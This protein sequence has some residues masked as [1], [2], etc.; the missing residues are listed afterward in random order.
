MQEKKVFGWMKILLDIL[1]KHSD[2]DK[3]LLCLC[4]STIGVILSSQKTH[5][6]FCTTNVLQAVRECGEGHRLYMVKKFFFGLIREEDPK[7]RD[8]VS[9]G[10]CTKHM[11]P[12]C[13]KKCGCDENF[14]CSKCCVQQR[15]FRCHTCDKEEIRFYCKTCWERDH[16]GHEC[17]EFFFPVR[18]G[19]K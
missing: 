3:N 17:E 16:Q 5:S 9:R 1:E 2:D 15:A 12:K 11:F 14:Y 6:M 7:V 10:F 8:A 13:R 4:C 18:C 19:K